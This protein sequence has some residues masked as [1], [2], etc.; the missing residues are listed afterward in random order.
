MTDGCAWL[1]DWNSN[2]G[3]FADFFSDPAKFADPCWCWSFLSVDLNIRNTQLHHSGSRGNDGKSNFTRLLTPN[4]QFMHNHYSCHHDGRVPSV[5][6][7][8]MWR[9]FNKTLFNDSFDSF[10]L[11]IRW[12]HWIHFFAITNCAREQASRAESGRALLQ[13]CLSLRNR[14]SR[15]EIAT[16]SSWRGMTAAGA[17]FQW[18]N[19]ERG[20]AHT[21]PGKTKVNI[22]FLLSCEHATP[23]ERF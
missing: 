20:L 19:G 12:N 13:W 9:T 1:D 14:C 8:F 3:C 11:Q 4:L 21:S 18:F 15:S 16:R 23:A 10:I 2:C 17:T 5:T 22:S 7:V 6:C